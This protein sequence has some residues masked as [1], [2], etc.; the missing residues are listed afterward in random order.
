MRKR[1]I[2]KRISAERISMSKNEEKFRNG[3][4]NPSST[5]MWEEFTQKTSRNC[6]RQAVTKVLFLRRY[7]RFQDHRSSVAVEYVNSLSS[8]LKSTNLF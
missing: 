4:G 5:S 1:S 3:H 8:S 2:L 7:C 6:S